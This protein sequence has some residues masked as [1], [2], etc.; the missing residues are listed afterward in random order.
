MKVLRVFSLTLN[1]DEFVLFY[2]RLGFLLR[3]AD[4]QDAILKFGFDIFL[5]YIFAYIE[6]SAA[7]SVVSFTT[8]EFAVAVMYDHVLLSTYFLRKDEVPA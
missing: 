4:L 7:G 8:D 5:F 2:Y 3:N 6:A 1:G